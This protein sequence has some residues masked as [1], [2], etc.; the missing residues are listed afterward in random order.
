MNKNLEK[1]PQERCCFQWGV[2]TLGKR[3]TSGKIMK[4]KICFGTTNRSQAA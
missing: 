3:S 2:S 1:T 4:I